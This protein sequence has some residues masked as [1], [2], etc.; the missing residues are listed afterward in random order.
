MKL[1]CIAATF[2]ATG[3]DT[4]NACTGI[5]LTAKDSTKILARTIEWGG[6]DLNSQYVIVP[7]GYTA[8]S[9]IPG[10]VDG[11]KFTSKYGYVGLAVEQKEFIA[12]GLNEEGLSA[13]LFYFP[14]YGK[15]EDYNP[16]Y[17]GESIADLQL[18]SWIL[19]ECKNV[20]EVKDAI[21]KIHVIAID[22][23]ASTVHWRFADTTGRQIVL[24][25]ID[26]KPVFYENKLGVLKTWRNRVVTVR[27]RKWFPR[28][29]WRCHSPIT[30]C[31]GCILSG[32][33]TSTGNFGR[34]SSAG[35]SDIK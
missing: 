27:C 14:K 1:M 17:K 30:I 16:A 2:A 19:G 4:A 12:E 33:G 35:I 25:I 31:K 24:E 13:G 21:S 20:E 10:G 18:V 26:G 6:S 8:Q 3:T 7:R 28:N 5:T 29:T 9:Y 15:Y 22:P 23:R 11:M 32:Y 34:N